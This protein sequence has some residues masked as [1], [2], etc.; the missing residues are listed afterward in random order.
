MDALKTAESDL[1]RFAAR[2][3]RGLTTTGRARLLGVS[4][5]AEDFRACLAFANEREKGT[6]IIPAAA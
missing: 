4:A 1:I 2:A 3:I 5:L 6:L